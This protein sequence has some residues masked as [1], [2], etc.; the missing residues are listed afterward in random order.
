MTHSYAR[1]QAWVGPCGE[2]VDGERDG[3]AGQTGMDQGIPGQWRKPIGS[4]HE[5]EGLLVQEAGN[6]LLSWRPRREEEGELVPWY[7]IL[8]GPF[9]ISAIFF[10][11]PQYIPHTFPPSRRCLP[12]WPGP[13]D[14]QRA[15]WCGWQTGRSQFSYERIGFLNQNE[16]ENI[17]QSLK[18]RGPKSFDILEQ[19]G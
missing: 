3:K 4:V 18:D 2:H 11:M 17:Q 12:T 10:G 5:E 19:E 9:D 13:R 15:V 8:I 7:Q 1:G 14:A 6:H 16:V